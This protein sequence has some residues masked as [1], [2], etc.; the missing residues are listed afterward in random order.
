MADLPL[1]GGPASVNVIAGG[2]CGGDLLLWRF[3]ASRA[4]TTC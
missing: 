2:R 1:A 4:S 3:A